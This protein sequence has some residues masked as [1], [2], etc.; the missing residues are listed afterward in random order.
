MSI[1]NL[2]RGTQTA[3]QAILLVLLTSGLLSAQGLTAQIS[4][5]VQDGNGNVVPNA[6]LTL[7]NQ[8]TQQ[9]RSA[10]SNDA[11][12]FVFTEVL[13]GT[14]TLT[15]S[16]TGFKT[17][18]Q[19]DIS[20]TATERVALPPITLELGQVNET[21]SVQ[22][23]SARLQTDSSERS[24]LVTSRQM[25]ELPLKGRDYLGTVKLIP[26]VLDTANRE[27]PGWNNLGG[28]TINGT[29]SGTVN[30]TLDGIS[31]LDTGSMTGPFLAPSADAVAEVKVM[32]TNYQAEYGRSSGGTI[33]TITKSGT[34]Q[35]HGGAY[36]FARN[37]AFNANEFFNNKAGIARPRY[38]YNDF[39]YLIGGP[40]YVPGYRLQ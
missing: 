31:S 27:A 16:Y 38:R 18:E 28:I 13:P 26:G 11:G 2:C 10:K 3:I 5:T 36:Y 15:T 37:E 39:G 4:G 25:V 1:L 12:A 6:D 34:S 17:A 7:T 30:L 23:E 32:L 20:A 9:K 33:N 14:F 35:F 22:A 19:K 8:Q 24:G 21:I 29:R 40:L